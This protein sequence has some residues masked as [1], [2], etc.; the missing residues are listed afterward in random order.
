MLTGFKCFPFSQCPNNRIGRFFSIENNLVLNSDLFFV[1]KIDPIASACGVKTNE[2]A[3]TGMVINLT[4]INDFYP[5]MHAKG[6]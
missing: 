2:V 5:C 3:K 6:N 4:S 1:R